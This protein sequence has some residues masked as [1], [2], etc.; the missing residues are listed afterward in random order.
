VRNKVNSTDLVGPS[1][2]AKWL[3]GPQKGSL[4]IQIR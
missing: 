2:Q 3:S 1:S 4:Q